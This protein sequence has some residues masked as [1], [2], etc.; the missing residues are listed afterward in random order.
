MGARGAMRVHDPDAGRNGLQA[1]TANWAS[2]SKG[3]WM[4]S[5]ASHTFQAKAIS[6]RIEGNLEG[7][8]STAER[9][10]S[11]E[12]LCEVRD[13][14][15]SGPEA[16]ESYGRVGTEAGVEGGTE[17]SEV[18]FGH[19]GFEELSVES[20]FLLGSLSGLFLHEK[21]GVEDL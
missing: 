14:R 19:F 20:D 17:Q 4:R 18:C 16:V 1:H 8:I 7:I 5:I 9:R 2:G 3:L 21:E 15:S 11:D 6:E 10:S 12:C 13:Q